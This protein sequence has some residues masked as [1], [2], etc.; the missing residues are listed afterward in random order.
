VPAKQG[1][2]K[3]AKCA[4]MLV[5]TAS[6]FSFFFAWPGVYQT[7]KR[8]SPEPP[9]IN[10]AAVSAIIETNYAA[11]FPAA[12]L[13]AAHRFREASAIRLR[14]SSLITRFFAAFFTVFDFG[15]S[16][17]EIP[18]PSNSRSAAIALSIAAFCCSSLLIMSLKLLS[19]RFSSPWLPRYRITS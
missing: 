16:D 18:L 8:A 6:R 14:P 1:C 17:S 5:D 10:L 19:N 12:F 13:T 9:P 15:L 11:F 7:D 2:R 4:G 3:I